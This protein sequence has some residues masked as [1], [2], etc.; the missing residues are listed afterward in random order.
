M[1]PPTVMNTPKYTE[2]LDLRQRA[3]TEPLHRNC[4]SQD[5]LFLHQ[6]LLFG[7]K[8]EATESSIW[9]VQEA[10]QQEVVLQ[11]PTLLREVSRSHHLFW[12]T[13]NHEAW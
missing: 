13:Y 8:N 4:I 7:Q 2:P 5:I 1:N 12:H 9:V 6:G 11:Q 10:Q 3:Y